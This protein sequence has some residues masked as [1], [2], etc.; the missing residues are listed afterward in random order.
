M[1]YLPLLGNGYYERKPAWFEPVQLADWAIN[2]LVLGTV[3]VLV[4]LPS[5]RPYLR[6]AP[7]ATGQA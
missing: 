4:A 7:D 1:T 6:K 2:A 3:A 5:A